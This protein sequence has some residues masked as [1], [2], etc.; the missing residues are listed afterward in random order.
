MDYDEIPGCC[1]LLVLLQLPVADHSARCYRRVSSD[2]SLDSR[3]SPRAGLW[4][5]YGLKSL[6]ERPYE[7]GAAKFTVD[8]LAVAGHHRGAGGLR[9]AAA[10]RRQASE[11]GCPGRRNAPTAAAGPR[12][13]SGPFEGYKPL[14]RN[15]TPWRSRSDNVD[16]TAL[17]VLP[18]TFPRED[19]VPN[20]ER[21]ITGPA[22]LQKF[23]PGIPPSVAAFHLGAE[24]QLGVF[25]S[26]K[27]RHEL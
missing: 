9:L 10:G 4:D 7:N 11:V 6:R 18:A 19:L 27:G 16:S 3:C 5:E 25:H 22:A 13:L 1:R 14:R 24:A 20:S 21:Y 12:Q 17:P 26:P 23:A 8:R 15:W 2:R